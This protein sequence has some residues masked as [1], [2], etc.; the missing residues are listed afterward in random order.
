[1]EALKEELVREASPVSAT[2]PL[3]PPST[4]TA[5]GAAQ[6]ANPTLP[7]P[8]ALQDRDQV[9]VLSQGQSIRPRRFVPQ[10]LLATAKR[11]TTLVL[12]LVAVLISLLAWDSYLTAPWTRDGR[13]RVQVA[14][15]APE[16]SGRIKDLRVADN[17][18]V[19]KGDVLFVIDPFDF[20]L[21]L[22]GSKAML[23]QR[24]ADLQV[25]ERQSERQRKLSSVATTPEQQ[26]I[27]AGNAIQAEAAFEAA[28][29]QV[30]L[31]EINLKRTEVRSP[32][33]GYVTN[34]LLRAGDYARQGVTNVSIID[35]DSFWIDGYFEETKMSHVCT[36]ARVEAKLM[37]YSAPIVGHVNTITR[38][39]SVSN[40]A[41]GAQGLPN[42]DPIYTWVRL[43]QR[44]P[45]RIAIDEV[46]PG[47]PL[48]SGM[49]ATVTVRDNS[50]ADHSWLFS[51]RASLF[52][53]LGSP[54][55][56]PDCIS[57]VIDSE[58]GQSVPAWEA[59]ATPDPEQINPGLATDIQASPR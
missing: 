19:R 1:M 38:G 4:Q 33:N 26:Q 54:P 48:V 40:A 36:G 15:V 13:V 21:A 35:T 22:H 7:A 42:V 23:Q 59:Q 5:D 10:V 11:L 31:A 32:V 52:N 51:A 55:A 34:L 50:A 9:A 41:A 44:V 8:V 29:Y 16:I 18:F 24:A 12:A 28:Q 6:E 56:N 20:N 45:V 53:V 30:A 2:E 17:Q 49:T 14:S 47:V 27:Y 46:P 3:N 58:P 25:K 43:A 57:P 39:L 37:G